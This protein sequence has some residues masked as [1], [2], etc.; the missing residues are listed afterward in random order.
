MWRRRAMAMRHGNGSTRFSRSPPQTSSVE[1][2]AV[3]EHVAG[4]MQV[5]GLTLEVVRENATFKVIRYGL[6]AAWVLLLP[7]LAWPLWH[8]GPGQR[9]RRLF[10][11]L[12]MIILIAVLA[13]RVLTIQLRQLVQ[14]IL[15]AA[16]VDHV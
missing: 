8:P 14:D 1:V 2:A 12:S 7:W 9:K 15:L 4:Q 11:A 13:P 3:L 16:I 6:A 5:R 10:A